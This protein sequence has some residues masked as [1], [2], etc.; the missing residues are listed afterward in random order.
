MIEYENAK[1][2]VVQFS[3]EKGALLSPCL[4][5]RYLLWR[6]WDEDVP[7]MLWIML[8]PSTA[9]AER[10]DATIRICMGRARRLGYGGIEVVN[11]FALR[12]TSPQ[13]LYTTPHPIS[14][15]ADPGRNDWEIDELIQRR[16]MI[17]CAWGQHGWL[18][19][20]GPAVFT[21]LK[22]KGVPLHA[23]KVNADGSPAHPLRIPYSQ[24]LVRL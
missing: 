17:V 9:D 18:S 21:R 13:A 6:I 5:Y 3:P 14:D 24:P 4:R 22:A 8:N 10:D 2:D 12:A 1:G 19:A 11:L 16:S 7:P 15:P 20:R 23:L